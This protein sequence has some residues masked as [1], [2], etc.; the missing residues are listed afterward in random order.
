MS[1]GESLGSHRLNS[2]AEFLQHHIESPK[3]SSCLTSKAK[4]IS[5]VKPISLVKPMASSKS[6]KKVGRQHRDNTT[7]DL[8]PDLYELYKSDPEESYGECKSRVQWI[9][10]YRAEQWFLSLPN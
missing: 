3:A 1:M 6:T 2:F 10:R 4:P 7:K 9:R 8:P 5:F